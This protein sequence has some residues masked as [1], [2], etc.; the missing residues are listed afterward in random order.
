MDE[1]ITIERFRA[2]HEQKGRDAALRGDSRDSHCM[3]P[4]HGLDDWFSGFD[5]VKAASQDLNHSALM[6]GRR[7]DV[8][9]EAS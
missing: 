4:S 9:Q 6:T 5:A 2:H 3:N 7:V 8:R 1:I